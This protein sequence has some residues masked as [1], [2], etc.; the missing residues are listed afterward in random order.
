MIYPKYSLLV[1]FFLVACSS[2]PRTPESRTGPTAPSSTSPTSSTSASSTSLYK[3]NVDE[4]RKY[5]SHG[6]PAKISSIANTWIAQAKRNVQD[7]V[8]VFA[9]EKIEKEGILSANPR[10]QK[11]NEALKN[12]PI[13]Y[14][15]AFCARITTGIDA[16]QCLA[17]TRQGIFRW[18]NKYHS[19]GN[20]INDSNLL[21]L[22]E[23]I[24][25]VLPYFSKSE[26][27][28]LIDWLN[29]FLDASDDYFSGVTS[30]SG[31]SVNNWTTWR[32]VI[33][34]MVS[35]LLGSL[36]GNGDDVEETQSLMDDHIKNNLVAQKKWTSVGSCKNLEKE[37]RYGSFDFRQ[38]DALH[39]HVYNLK[40]WSILTLLDPDWFQENKR[41]VLKEA[42]EFLKPYV[43]RE[44]QHVEFVCSPVKFDEQ[45]RMAGQQIYQHA[46]W[47][48]EDA[49]STLFLAQVIFPE[50]KSWMDSVS[51]QEEDPFVRFL[52]EYK[53]AHSDSH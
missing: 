27:T 31:R 40:A 9:A 46:P 3:F 4:I 43:T 51:S 26:K 11:S 39:Y 49:K 15:Y 12:L 44:K 30:V 45:R 1:I 48:P 2:A 18:V 6:T 24:D 10:Y 47:N 16:A 33:R 19:V 29:E 7:G 17:K 53:N 35:K 38:R 20:S 37:T 25:W 13:L 28:E 22:F 21:L 42:V 36:Q 32:L 14:Q 41:D 50:E 34:M 52:V 5:I 8:E 23:S